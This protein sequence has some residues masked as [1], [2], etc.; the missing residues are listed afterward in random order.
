[1]VKFR[2]AFCVITLIG[3]ATANAHGVFVPSTLIG[4]YE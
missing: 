3:I 1:M 4:V 2:F